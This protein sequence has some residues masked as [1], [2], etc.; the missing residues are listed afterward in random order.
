MNSFYLKFS[1]NK[2]FLLNFVKKFFFFFK[3]SKISTTE[4]IT[5][6]ELTGTQ[7]IRMVLKHNPSLPGP[8]LSLEINFGPLNVIFSPRQLYLVIE[9]LRG[10]SKPLTEQKLSAPVQKPMTESDFN[11]IELDLFNHVDIRP[12]ADVGLRGMQGWSNLQGNSIIL[13]RPVQN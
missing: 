6:A 13:C 8:K 2:E 3:N 9:I 10:I 5:I 1:C 12:D 4:P 11:R 7:I